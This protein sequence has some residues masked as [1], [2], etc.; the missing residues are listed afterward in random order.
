MLV[1]EENG[2]EMSDVGTQHLL[3]E[4]GT[5]IDDNGPTLDLNKCRGT[6]THI[7]CIA[8]ATHLATTA[9]NRN[10]LRRSRA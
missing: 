2:I 8:R 5:R 1:R 6:Q 7:P 10:T 3:S 4:V 9:N